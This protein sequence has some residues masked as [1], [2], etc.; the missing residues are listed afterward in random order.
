MNK[1]TCCLISSESIPPERIKAAERE[2]AAE[3]VHAVRSGYHRFI[4]GFLSAADLAFC[5]SIVALRG[6]NTNISL[7]AAISSRPL[8]F[9][10]MKD[11]A[12]KSALLQ[13]TNIGVHAEAESEHSTDRLYN[14]MI[15][16]TG[17][18]I[19][20]TSGASKDAAARAVRAAYEAG[21]EVRIIGGN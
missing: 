3:V 7:E 8:L 2:I 13:C 18:V 16:N 14:F 15:R 12:I 1:T 4:T 6:E 9:E 19:A 20:F 21:C 11:D 17:R 10:M 5:Q